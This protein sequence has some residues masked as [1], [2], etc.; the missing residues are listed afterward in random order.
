MNNLEEVR[1]FIKKTPIEM[2]IYFLHIGIDYKEK[3]I[4]NNFILIILIEV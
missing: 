1:T 3:K 4:L 2:V